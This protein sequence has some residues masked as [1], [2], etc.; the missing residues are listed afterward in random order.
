M[1]T[2]AAIFLLF[3]LAF[4]QVSFLPPLFSPGWLFPLSVIFMAFI[5]PVGA[6]MASAT[7]GGFIL[8]VYSSF[9]FG[10]WM[11]VSLASFLSARYLFQYYVRFPQQ[12]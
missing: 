8:D 9:P 11:V 1:K 3:S 4:L 6:G 12:G 2:A 7:L 10:F 5:I